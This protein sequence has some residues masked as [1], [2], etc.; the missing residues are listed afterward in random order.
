MVIE[1]VLLLLTKKI[2]LPPSFRFVVLDV[3]AG[4]VEGDLVASL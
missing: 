2:A 4:D 1:P 3:A